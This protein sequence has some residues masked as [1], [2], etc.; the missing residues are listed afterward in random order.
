MLTSGSFLYLY[1][2]CFDR[3]LSL[4]ANEVSHACTVNRTVCV[5]SGFE[6]YG[7]GSLDSLYF[8]MEPDV[9]LSSNGI[10]ILIVWN[11]LFAV[12]YLFYRE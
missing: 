11:V 12:V 8:E 6:S 9:G 2:R 5:L 1:F 4:H 10:R 3:Q 7:F